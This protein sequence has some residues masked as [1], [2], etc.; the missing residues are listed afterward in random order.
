MDTVKKADSVRLDMNEKLAL[1]MKIK[2]A[3]SFFQDRSAPDRPDNKEA[4]P[5]HI[6][7]MYVSVD[8][9]SRIEAE[10]K[11]RDSDQFSEPL[12]SCQD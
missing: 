12:C 3:T 10:R 1:K 2:A 9:G 8:K 5:E 11:V 4:L 6:A 7:R